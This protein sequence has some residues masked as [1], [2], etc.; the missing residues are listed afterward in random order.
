MSYI[1][2]HMDILFKTDDTL[3]SYRVGGI[4]IH[5]DKVL[6]Q[7]PKDD[8]FAIIG[9]HVMMGE[10]SK[11]ALIREFKEELR[12]DIEINDLLSTGEIFFNWNNK[13]CH[14][15]C[16]YYWAKLLSDMQID[17]VIHG[18]DEY[19]DKRIDLDYIWVPLEDIRNGLQ[20]YPLEIIP[21][22]LKEKNIPGHFIS[23]EI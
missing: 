22:L 14:Q 20:V 7:R 17:G 10:N 1:G 16:I 19:G 13:K 5:N 6:L 4:L 23:K 8:D 11:E 2:G 12:I 18:Y 21:F 3:F 9:G 15:I